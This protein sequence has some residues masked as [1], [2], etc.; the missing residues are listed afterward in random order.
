M[1]Q[2]LGNAFIKVNAKK[3]MCRYFKNI[4]NLKQSG[5]IFLEKNR[6]QNSYFNINGPKETVA[7]REK[8]HIYIN[9]PYTVVV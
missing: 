8:L 3:Y 5:N 4:C 6:F 1:V 9:I 2:Q 7:T